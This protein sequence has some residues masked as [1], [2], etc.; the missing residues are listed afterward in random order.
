LSTAAHNSARFTYV[1]PAGDLGD[2]RGSVIDGGYF[3]NFGALS[4]LEIARAAK[5]VLKD[6]VKLVI[7]MISSDPNLEDSHTLVRINE[8]RSGGKCLVSVAE[9]ERQSPGAA[10]AKRQPNYFSVNPEKNANTLV[11]EFVAP[12]QGLENVREA[13]GNRAA[14]ELAVEICAEFPHAAK[15]GAGLG[16]AGLSPQMQTAATLNDS[17]DVTV[18]EVHAIEARPENPYFAHLTM[19][20]VRKPGEPEPI[21]P[22]LGWVLSKATQDRFPDLLKTCGNSPELTQLE[23]A[24]GKPAPQ[25]ARGQ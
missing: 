8:V 9:R 14:A 21:Q 11:N 7:L 18:A 16:A 24:L 13:H 25:R 10:D 5:L 22:P 20:K 2:K 12:I 23:T 6:D 19:C 15:P 1:S 17:K 4:A 3:E